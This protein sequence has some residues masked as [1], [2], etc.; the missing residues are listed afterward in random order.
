MIKREET[1]RGKNKLNR[2]QHLKFSI[3]KIDSNVNPRRENAA[4]CTLK[5]TAE[6]IKEHTK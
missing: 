5:L 3:F 6:T 1:N 2:H 4:K